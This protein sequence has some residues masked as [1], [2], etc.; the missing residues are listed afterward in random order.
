MA[1]YRLISKKLR[2]GVRRVFSLYFLKMV[3]NVL[4]A[5]I[6]SRVKCLALCIFF[7][8]DIYVRRLE[9][10][11]EKMIPK[12]NVAFHKFHLQQLLINTVRCLHCSHDA[13]E[14][15]QETRR[16][17]KERIR[18]EYGGEEKKMKRVKHKFVFM[19]ILCRV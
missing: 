13:H 1:I 19:S 12:S 16:S 17:T 14:N 15:P 5:M 18:R 8:L 2:A 11:Q 10:R 7:L 9:S 4:A 3:D 6:S